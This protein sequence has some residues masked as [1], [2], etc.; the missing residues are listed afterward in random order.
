MRVDVEG[1]LDRAV[2]DLGAHVAHIFPL[3][4]YPGPVSSCKCAI[5]V[6]GGHGIGRLASVVSI[7]V[8]DDRGGPSGTG[9]CWAATDA[10]TSPFTPVRVVTC[11]A[12]GSSTKGSRT[13]SWRVASPSGSGQSWAS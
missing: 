1:Q 8:L 13:R 7:N 3:G 11:A 5:L 9:C 10:T 12:F 4:E 2:T 6:Q